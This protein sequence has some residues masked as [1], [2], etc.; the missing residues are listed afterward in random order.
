MCVNI[1]NI[2]INFENQSWSSHGASKL[3]Y[4]ELILYVAGRFYRCTTSLKVR[5]LMSLLYVPPTLLT[6]CK[7]GLTDLLLDCE[8][9]SDDWVRKLAYGAL[10]FLDE[11]RK[12]DNRQEPY[13]YKRG[14]E[15]SRLFDAAEDAWPPDPE[16][17][18]RIE[19]SIMNSSKT[20]QAGGHTGTT[21]TGPSVATYVASLPPLE[22]EVKHFTPTGDF[23]SFMR[24][25]EAQ[26]FA[27]ISR[28]LRN[29]EHLQERRLQQERLAVTKRGAH[30]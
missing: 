21:S 4:R 12:D 9:E 3:L 25:I 6:E 15:Y 2:Y 16:V 26:G 10:K 18:R 17:S 19:S 29:V 8:T 24:D 23:S 22:R 14:V 20:R 5:I 1:Y 28:E 11:Q 13:R 30:S 7:V 27:A